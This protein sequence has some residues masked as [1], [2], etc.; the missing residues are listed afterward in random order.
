MKKI[1]IVGSMSQISEIMET[2]DRLQVC[3][4]Y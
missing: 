1:F 2:R 3:K 4:S